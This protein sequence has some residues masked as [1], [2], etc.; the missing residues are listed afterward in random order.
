MRRTVLSI[1]LLGLLILIPVVSSAA[2]PPPDPEWY[3]YAKAG[4]DEYKSLHQTDL[5]GLLVTLKLTA[6]S[7]GK[8]NAYPLEFVEGSFFNGGP[9]YIYLSIT[10]G[11][12]YYVFGENGGAMTKMASRANKI[13]RQTM[14]QLYFVQVTQTSIFTNR[15]VSLRRG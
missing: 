1:F 8:P 3:D 14:G 13:R 5:S 9:R 11:E 7:D 12:H 15:D 10:G 4:V 6:H 2:P